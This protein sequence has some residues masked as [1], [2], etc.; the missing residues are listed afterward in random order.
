MTA[1]VV[2]DSAPAVTIRAR[3][4]RRRLTTAER[5]QRSEQMRRAWRDGKFDDRKPRR[6]P[7]HW[8]PEQNDTLKVLAGTRPVP[9]IVDA[10][11]RRFHIRRTQ[12]SIRIQA[13]RLGISL[14]QGGYS[15]R[16]I[17]RIFGTPHHTITPL[18]IEAGYLT[19]YRWK[20]RGPN[21][22]W[23]FEQAEVERFVRECGW[24]YHLDKMQPGH[25]LTRLAQITHRADPWIVGSEAVARVLGLA[26][27]NLYRW[28]RR[29]LVPHKRRPMGGGI[30]ILVVRGRDVPAI[31]AAIS[32][33]QREARARQHE[34]FRLAARERSSRTLAFTQ[35]HADR[36]V[37]ACK[38]GHPRTIETTRLLADGRLS[39][40]M[41]RAERIALGKAV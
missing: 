13:K 21:P 31:R 17:E 12:A 38:N 33:A 22:G 18:W 36:L 6:H 35:Q 20:A 39:C 8:T 5:R 25:K 27:R 19:G 29:G 40:V 15:L 9:E 30:G 10:L 14:W 2:R 28:L 1:P 3:R 11:E 41:C 34:R 7:R 24:L 4:T 32:E 16:E 23:W 26:S 37:G